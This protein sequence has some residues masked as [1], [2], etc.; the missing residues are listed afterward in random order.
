M[1]AVRHRGGMMS[2][3]SHVCHPLDTDNEALKRRQAIGKMGD[4]G[5]LESELR[6]EGKTREPAGLVAQPGRVSARRRDVM[7]YDVTG[8]APASR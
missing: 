8:V 5:V 1:I 2:T 6:R 7:G 4:A 3:Y